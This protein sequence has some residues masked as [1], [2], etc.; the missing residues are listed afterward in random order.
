MKRLEAPARA[1]RGR[2]VRRGRLRRAPGAGQGLHRARR[3]WARRAASGIRYLVDPRVVDGTRWVTGADEPGRHVFD[4]VAGRDFTADGTIEAAEVRDGDP[5]PRLRRRRSR[6]PAA[7]RSAT[8]SSSAAS[9]PRRSA[10]RCSTRTASSSPSPWAPTASASRARSPRSPRA[11]YDELGLCWPREVAPA[12]VHIVATGKDDGR[13]SPPPSGSPRELDAPGVAC[14]STTGASVSPGVKFKDAELIG[15]PTIVVV[16]RGLADGVVEVRTGAPASARDVPVADAAARR[17]R[18]DARARA[19]RGRRRGGH[20]RLGRHAD[21]VARRRPR[22]SSGTPTRGRLR[23]R[24]PRPTSSPRGCIEAERRGVGAA[25]ATTSRA[26]T[27]DD[28]FAAAGLE[29]A[30]TR[31]ERRW[32][33]TTTSGSRT[34]STDPECARDARPALRE[35]GLK[36]GVLSN[37]IWP[38][39]CHEEVFERDGVSTSSTGPSTPARSRGPS[40]T[41]EAFRA[42]MAAVG[43]D[44]PAACVFVG[45]R[46]FDDI[47][48]AKQV[49]MR[50]VPVPHSDHPGQPA[51][52]TPRG[53]R[54]PWSTGWLDLLR[55]GRRRGQPDARG[56]RRGRFAA[57]ASS[58]HR[59]GRRQSLSRAAAV[60]RHGARRRSRRAAA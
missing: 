5:C 48:G 47:Y 44:D 20:L 4:L 24:A 49:G 27:L 35:R 28:L 32:P 38:R 46:L 30:G 54:T 7:S 11:R 53:S 39:E 15:V 57:A 6:S 25:A 56:R 12:D 9:T 34:P 42:A 22:A 60:R 45:D 18:A 55:A 37:T 10:S 2:A 1:G 23:R 31:H 26:A 59:S 19:E 13:S 51:R 21:A 40:R 43:V 29:P 52:A 3:R 58:V 41:P 14:C 16:G 17:R 33:P 50:A 8:S 36:V